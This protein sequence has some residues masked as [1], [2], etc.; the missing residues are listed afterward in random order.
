MPSNE[1]KTNVNIIHN[2][3]TINHTITEKIEK[4][5]LKIVI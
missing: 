3:I 5:Y 2:F 1:N 4:N